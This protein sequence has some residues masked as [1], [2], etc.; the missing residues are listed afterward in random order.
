M[1]E[2]GVPTVVVGRAGESGEVRFGTVVNFRRRVRLGGDPKRAYDRTP[3]PRR[4]S[5][6]GGDHTAVVAPVRR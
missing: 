1:R 5:V 4:E 6:G 2:E 3:W